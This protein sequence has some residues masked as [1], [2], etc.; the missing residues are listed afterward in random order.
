MLLER[1]VRIEPAT[2]G[3]ALSAGESRRV[4]GMARVEVDI[5]GELRR[6]VERELLINP[7]TGADCRRMAESV[8]IDVDIRLA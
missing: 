7:W 2:E 8:G 6:D 5:T 4:V 3:E 1:A